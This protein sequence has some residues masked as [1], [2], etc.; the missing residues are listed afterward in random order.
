MKGDKIAGGFASF[1][2]AWQEK[3]SPPAK[4]FVID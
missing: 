2:K 4:F 1:G 3:C